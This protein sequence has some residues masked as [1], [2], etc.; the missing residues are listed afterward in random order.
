M[1][2]YGIPEG[3]IGARIE[4]YSHDD[5]YTIRLIGDK[6]IELSCEGECC[7]HSWFEHVDDLGAFPGTILSIDDDG[8][9]PHEVDET[10]YEDLKTY[11]LT[12]KTDKGRFTVDMRNSSNGYYGGSFVWSIS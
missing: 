10:D 8:E 1:S 9:T 11:F 6:T 7:S 12:I 3:V 4:S 2:L 5:S